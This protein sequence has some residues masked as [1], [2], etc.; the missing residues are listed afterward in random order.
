MGAYPSELV[1]QWESEDGTLIT[2]RPI[3]PEDAAIEYDFVHQLS[4]RSKYLRFFS[5]LNELTPSMLTRFTHIDYQR[6]M[7]L[8][9]TLMKENQEVEIA[10]GRFVPYLGGKS[11]EFALV[12]GDEWQ[13]HGIGYQ[14]MQ[15]LIKIG[16]ARQFKTMKGL[17]LSGNLEM[18]Q[19]VKDL[20]FKITPVPGD[21]KVVEAVK[22]L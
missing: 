17:I 9:A 18:L 3:R 21:A 12:V 19:L 20:G 6:E 2:I 16:R 14:I 10:V 22:E 11:C 5:G 7:A 1:R 15:D 13:R 4:P 8:I